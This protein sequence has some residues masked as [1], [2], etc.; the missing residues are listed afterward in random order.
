MKNILASLVVFALVFQAA[1]SGA[2]PASEDSTLEQAGY[3][4]GSVLGTLV[5]APFKT[6]LCVLGGIGAAFTA[7]AS[8]PAAGQVVG[9]SCGGTWLITPDVVRG[10]ESVKFVG[11]T[12]RARTVSTD[13]VA[14]R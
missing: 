12:R 6:T 2:A 9:A 1:P 5:Y 3:G 13:A 11:D 10:E 8:R 7:I 4:A 14:L